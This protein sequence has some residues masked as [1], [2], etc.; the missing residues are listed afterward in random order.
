[1]K[2]KKHEIPS[3]TRRTFAIKEHEK[4]TESTVAKRTTN[5]TE[6]KN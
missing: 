5:P 2:L 4:R 1:M 3:A 6:E